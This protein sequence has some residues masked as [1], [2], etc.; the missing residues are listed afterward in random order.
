MALCPD[1]ND[2][3]RSE[4]LKSL[5]KGGYNGNA[6][7]ISAPR[8]GAGDSQAAKLREENSLLMDTNNALKKRVEELEMQVMELEEAAKSAEEVS[9]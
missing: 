3:N 1:D 7:S 6:N 9:E 8:S 4:Q 5:K 2:P